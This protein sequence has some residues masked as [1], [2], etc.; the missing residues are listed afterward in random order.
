M[1]CMHAWYIR[2][3][4]LPLLTPAT[5]RQKAHTDERPVRSTLSGHLPSSSFVIQ[6]HARYDQKW[7]PACQLLS[8]SYA[9]VRDFPPIRHPVRRQSSSPTYYTCMHAHTYT[10]IIP[11]QSTGSRDPDVQ[12]A[13]CPSAN[14]VGDLSASRLLS[15]ECTPHSNVGPWQ[16][17]SRRNQGT[18]LIFQGGSAYSP[19]YFRPRLSPL[20][21]CRIAPAGDWWSSWSCA[22]YSCGHLMSSSF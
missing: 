1:A 14:H 8:H 4:L 18:D 11:T 3:S 10:S 5:L 12:R 13:S 19:S 9:T 20:Q 16:Q 22:I 2:T 6:G 21:L 17:S 7:R 15:I